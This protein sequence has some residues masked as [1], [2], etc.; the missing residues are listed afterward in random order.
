MGA[1][2]RTRA[3]VYTDSDKYIDTVKLIKQSPE[4]YE[5]RNLSRNNAS[6]SQGFVFRRIAAAESHL[7]YVT[8]HNIK[9]PSVF[10]KFT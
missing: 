4:N 9:L 3:H 2:K 1:C 5:R 10:A 6:F 8:R 7:N